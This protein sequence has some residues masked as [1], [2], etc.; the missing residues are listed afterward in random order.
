MPFFKFSFFLPL[1]SSLLYDVLKQFSVNFSLRIQIEPKRYRNSSK[2]NHA[3]G[4]DS[5]NERT[6]R[7]LFA[8]FRSTDF[9]LE[10]EP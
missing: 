1:F 7:R 8:K 2:I 5:V 6:V 10:D 3:F 9:S 4:N